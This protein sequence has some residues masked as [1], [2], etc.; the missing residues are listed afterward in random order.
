[1][2]WCS[3]PAI[4][5]LKEYGYSVLRLPR[6][7]Y[8]PLQI[9]ARD[10]SDL[11]PVGL[12]TTVMVP[13]ADVQVPKVRTDTPAAS[14]NGQKTSDISLSIGLDI[15]GTVIGA[16][17]GGKLGLEAKYERARSVAFEF[18]EVMEDKVQIAELDQYLGGSDIN[19]RSVHMRT[20]LEAD[21]IYV[22]TS[23][24]KSSKVSVEAKSKSGG[25]L[26]VSIPEIKE[27]VGGK[28]KVSGSAERASKVTFEGSVQLVFGFQAVKL[29]Y[30]NGRYTAF[31]PLGAGEM[32]SRALSR[33]TLPNRVRAFTAGGPFAR[34]VTA[35]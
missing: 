25:S 15:L 16:M 31:E 3:D 10:G 6:A 7:D 26:D 35:R 12:V 19:P 17:G 22:V 21:E 27:V 1:M 4:T 18:T 14:I 30:E 2:T 11:V 20:L 9:L 24:L 32:A 28:V 8:P 23:T 13:G 5:Y 34:V 33:A 29:F